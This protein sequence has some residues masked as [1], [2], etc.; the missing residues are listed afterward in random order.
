MPLHRRPYPRNGTTDATEIHTD[1]CRPFFHS[2]RLYR[3][4]RIQRIHGSRANLNQKR[5]Y[6]SYCTAEGLGFTYGANIGPFWSPL[7][8]YPRDSQ[9]PL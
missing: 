9:Y 8:L 7:L 1:R 3:I 4:L 6:S 2:P 5:V